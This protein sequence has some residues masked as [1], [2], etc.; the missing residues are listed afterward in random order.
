MIRRPPRSTLSSSSAASDVYKRQVFQPASKYLV[1]QASEAKSAQASRL[2]TSLQELFPYA[3]QPYSVKEDLVRLNLFAQERPT[4]QPHVDEFL[5]RING[6]LCSPRKRIH[7]EGQDLRDK[8]KALRRKLSVLYR[9]SDALDEK[10]RYAEEKEAVAN[11][12]IERATHRAAELQQMGRQVFSPEQPLLY[13]S[14]Q[15]QS[16][17]SMST[18]LKIAERSVQKAHDARSRASELYNSAAS[19]SDIVGAEIKDMEHKFEKLK[20]KVAK[21]E[22]MGVNIEAAADAG[23]ALVAA[24]GGIRKPGVQAAGLTFLL[25][26]VLVLLG[27]IAASIFLGVYIV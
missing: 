11:D 14:D 20:Y 16:M 1:N 15:R 4:E 25:G 9:Q 27:Y 5:G 23:H 3:E 10:L 22:R 8:E 19:K 7:Q 12:C 26:L 24:T 21:V 18:E 13:L 17:K 6:L 2:M